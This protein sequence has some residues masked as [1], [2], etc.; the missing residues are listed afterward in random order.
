MVLNFLLQNSGKIVCIFNEIERLLN[1]W[2][3]GWK[4][5]SGRDERLCS[6]QVVYGVK[7][8]IKVIQS[9]MNYKAWL[10]NRYPT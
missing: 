8:S 4:H 6:Q 7:S 3:M 1:S 9:A 2:W 5:L 10:P